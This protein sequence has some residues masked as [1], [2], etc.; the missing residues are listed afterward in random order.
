MKRS[1]RAEASNFGYF[2]QRDSGLGAS[3]QPAGA[4]AEAVRFDAPRQWLRRGNAPATDRRREHGFTARLVRTQQFA[5]ARAQ[6]RWA[7][8]FHMN[9]EVRQLDAIDAAMR[10]VLDGCHQAGARPFVK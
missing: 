5:Q 10:A 9:I 3:D 2:Q 7:V 1:G 6:T 8:L 4:S